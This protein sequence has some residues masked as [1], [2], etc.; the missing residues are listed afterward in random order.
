MNRQ[1][2]YRGKTERDGPQQK[3]KKKKKEKGEI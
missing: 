3:R 1:N 2:S